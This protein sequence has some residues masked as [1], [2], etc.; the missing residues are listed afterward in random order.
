MKARRLF[1]IAGALLAVSGQAWA[2]YSQGYTPPTAYPPMTA[3]AP[4]GAGPYGAGPYGAQPMSMPCPMPAQ[5]AYMPG[6]PVGCP[7]ACDDCPPPWA[8][9][10]FSVYGDYLYMRPR[11][12]AIA[13][14]VVFNGPLATPPDAATPVQV[15]PPGEVRIGFQS[16]YRAGA[17]YA[18]TETSAVAGTYTHFQGDDASSISTDTFLI[19]SMVSHPSTWVDNAESDFLQASGYNRMK[20][21]LGDVDYRWTFLQNCRYMLTFI[22]GARY[23]ELDQDFRAH[24][25]FNTEETV[26]TRVRFE[27]AGLRLGLEGER[28]GCNWGLFVY[29]RG[30]ASFMA[31][32]SRATYLQVNN[33]VTQV[34]TGYRAD[35]IVPT[36]D[37]ELGVGWMS[38]GERI[39]ISAG[40]MMSAWY[41]VVKTDEFIQAVQHNNFIGLGDTLTFDGLVAHAEVRF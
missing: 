2:Q 9:S 6:V 1:L 17:S 19:R 27:G 35:L 34:E 20:F 26:T 11:N 23:G 13:Y 38:A 12:E 10:K 36:L 4:P 24:F 31:G 40:Y 33:F 41:N 37:L 22:G 39:K 7:S 8:V 14:G 28:H 18:L 21:D 30:V 32:T 29:G 16:A 25:L 15:A 5:G 3:Y